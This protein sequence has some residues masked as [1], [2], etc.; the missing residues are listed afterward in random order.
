MGGKAGWRHAIICFGVESST[1]RH[2]PAPSRK[3]R[4]LAASQ[5]WSGQV[6]PYRFRVET[7]ISLKWPESLS[8]ARRIG[9]QSESSVAVAGLKR[10]RLRALRERYMPTGRSSCHCHTT[11]T[12]SGAPVHASTCFMSDE[13][14]QPTNSPSSAAE[15][16]TI[17]RRACR[18]TMRSC[19]AAPGGSSHTSP[20]ATY[21]RF[22]A[23]LIAVIR[24]TCG[25]SSRKK[26]IG[27]SFVGTAV[28][29]ISC[30]TSQRPQR[31]STLLSSSS[32]ALPMSALCE[33]KACSSRMGRRS[34]DLGTI[35]ERRSDVGLE[36]A[37]PS[38]DCA[39]ASALRRC[40]SRCT[41]AAVRVE[42]LVI[43]LGVFKA[44]L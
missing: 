33:P 27:E 11:T 29:S 7:S 28:A 44:P 14:A 3:T 17:V 39:S 19:G 30:E 18:W 43:L 35:E 34:C 6:D 42:R 40:R 8:L 10:T 2:A 16:T 20:T 9:L 15:S 37:A 5:Q 23:M 25:L 32:T 1:T 36:T 38:A 26:S 13:K 31:C 4:A 22:P 24:L 21:L 41:S 12:C